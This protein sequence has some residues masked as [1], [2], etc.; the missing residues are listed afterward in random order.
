MA[1]LYSDGVGSGLENPPI[2]LVQ[3]LATVRDADVQANTDRYVRLTMAKLP[4]AYA[5]TPR[6]MLRSLAWYF[7][8]IWIE[9]TPTRILWWPGGRLDEPPRQWVAPAGTAAP[10]SDPA[11]P[12]GQP[13]AWS[14]HP[15]DW[16]RAAELTVRELSMRDLT[17]VGPDGFPVCVPV[18]GIRRRPEGF[19]LR[20]PRVPGFSPAGPACLT[21]HTHDETFTAQQ[22]R[23]FV[24]HI[25]DTDDDPTVRLDVRRVLGSWSVPG[26]KLGATVDLIRKGRMLRPRLHA[27]CARR[28][29]PVPR[30]RLPGEHRP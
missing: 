2:A 23:V 9:V 30:V 24:G 20:V 8:R 25:P 21:F 16:H 5:G 26:N 29:R 7:A 3:G 10:P 13:G 1:L 6:F 19:Q 17:F 12:G 28:G 11:P 4:A 15:V 22:N 14:Q 27:E 18:Q